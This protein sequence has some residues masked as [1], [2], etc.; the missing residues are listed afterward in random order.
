M[1][2][3]WYGTGNIV[4]FIIDLQSHLICISLSLFSAVLCVAIGESYDIPKNLRRA[5]ELYVDASRIIN[6]HVDNVLSTYTGNEPLSKGDDDANYW[7]PPHS[8]R[9]VRDQFI[10]FVYH[11]HH[12]LRHILM[13]IFVNQG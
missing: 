11:L 2:H 1:L 10:A 5:Y 7:L 9:V 4:I 13:E 8:V 12:D 6:G 3:I